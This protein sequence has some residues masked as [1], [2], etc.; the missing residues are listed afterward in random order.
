MHA[1]LHDFAFMSVKAI[2]VPEI[3]EGDGLEAL[4]DWQDEWQVYLGRSRYYHAH[5]VEPQDIPD[6]WPT[7]AAEGDENLSATERRFAEETGLASA[8]RLRQANVTLYCDLQ[9]AVRGFPLLA[10]TRGM[11]WYIQGLFFL[12][13]G[14]H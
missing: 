10:K 3:V 1:Q 11:S 7:E 12:Q 5:G 9:F 4:P 14:A 13:Q 6:E 2:A 8:A